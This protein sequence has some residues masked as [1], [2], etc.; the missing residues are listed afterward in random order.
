[1][2]NSRMLNYFRQMRFFQNNGVVLKT[3][4]MLREKYVHLSDLRYVLEPRMSETELVDSVNYLI[5]GG[6]IN[7]R[8]CITKQ[9]IA[10]ADCP[11]EEL[12]VK[13]S[14]DGIQIISCAKTDNCIIV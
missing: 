5:E 11:F 12:E 10:L 4:N 3:I 1:M 14:H 13:V 7:T 6:Y 8:S 9:P 2:E